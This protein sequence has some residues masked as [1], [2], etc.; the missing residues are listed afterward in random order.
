MFFAVF[1]FGLLQN[2]KNYICL[3]LNSL[4]Q[5]S[6]FKYQSHS[7]WTFAELNFLLWLG[8]AFSLLHN[9][10]INFDFDFDFQ[11]CRTQFSISILIFSFVQLNFCIDGCTEFYFCRTAK[12]YARSG[13]AAR[14]EIQNPFLYIW[15]QGAVVCMDVRRKPV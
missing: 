3:Y 8:T 13:T 1:D 9:S 4:L 7:F 14:L 10:K 11:F 6:I 15:M 5:N 12:I 2:L